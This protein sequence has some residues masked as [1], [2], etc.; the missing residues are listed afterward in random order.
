MNLEFKLK[1]IISFF[2]LLLFLILIRVGFLC[3]IDYEKMHKLS[4]LPRYK[5]VTLPPSRGLIADRGGHLLAG[6]QKRFDIAIIYQDIKAIPS[7]TYDPVTGTKSP[8][9]KLYISNLSQFLSS[10][11]DLT[12]Q[13][14]EDFIYAKSALFQDIP[15]TLVEDITLS[16]YH[17]LKLLQSQWPGLKILISQKRHYPHQKIGSHV[18]GFL[19]AIDQLTYQKAQEE[20]KQ[21]RTYI[22]QREKGLTPPLPKG[23]NTPFE[24]R[25]RFDELSQKSYNLVDFVGI[26]GVEKSCDHHLRGGCGKKAYET[27]RLGTFVSDLPGSF[28]KKRPASIQLCIDLALQEKA[29][30]LLAKRE[31][32][33]DLF[34]KG[35]AIVVL[36]IKTSQVL[37]LASYPRFNPQDFIDKNNAKIHQWTESDLYLR[38]LYEG[39]EQIE[40]ENF[41]IQKGFYATSKRLN[42]PL[43][44]QRLLSQNSSC[45]AALLNLP[46][47]KQGYLLIDSFEKLYEKYGFIEPSILLTQLQSNQDSDE[48]TLC[49]LKPLEPYLKSIKDPLLFLD[50]L[51]LLI[52][53]KKIK[54]SA[55]E[56][57]DQIDLSTFFTLYQDLSYILKTLESALQK[58]F[59]NLIFSSW[60]SEH[61]KTFL[62]EKRE[63]ET[64]QKTY[65]RPYTDYLQKEKNRQYQAFFKKYKIYM[66][67]FILNKLEHLKQELKE[68]EPTLTRLKTEPCL[69]LWFQQTQHLNLEQTAGLI[70]AIRPFEELTRP[71]YGH[72]PLLDPKK[73]LEKDLALAFYPKYK[74]GYLKS[75]AH[76]YLAP[77]GS[78]FKLVVAYQALKEKQE[79]KISHLPL[80]HDALSN[81][82]KN[83]KEQILGFD[84][85]KQPIRRWHKGGL[86]PR[87]SHAGIG[88]VDL[89]GA[90]EQSSNIYFSIL[91][92]ETLENPLELLKTARLMGLGSKTGIDLPFE[93]KGKL[94]NDLHTNKTGLYA[95]AIGQHELLVTPLQTAQMLA[96]LF[97]QG[98]IRKPQIVASIQKQVPVTDDLFSRCD[99]HPYTQSLS[100]LG[101]FFPLFTETL[102]Q[103]TERVKTSIESP[104][105]QS[106]TMN[107]AILDPLKKGMDR[108]VWGQKGT[109]R[110]QAIATLVPLDELRE[111]M[112]LKHLMIGKTGTAE[113]QV[114]DTF[115]Q[116]A[117]PRMLNHIWF[118]CISFEDDTQTNPEL[119]ICIYLKDG[120]LGVK[121]AAPLAAELIQFYQK[122]QKSTNSQ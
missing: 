65:A 102:K 25:T 97:D 113:Q 93:M 73:H 77:Q 110:P 50:L 45:H 32:C 11:C 106:Y 28:E 122:N 66:L 99:E 117:K 69:Q 7:Q 41:S 105:L 90:L 30:T 84:Q 17:Q 23:F 86:L 35:G 82:S 60:R 120:H 119:A 24:V 54:K 20:K 2:G 8:T 107:A 89:V 47:V 64:A 21:L 108:A 5:S 9:R 19:G 29:E 88:T 42:Y 57:L 104:L 56:P 14:I 75:H 81:E 91:A 16:A 12:P 1:K 112:H 62:K 53:P 115:D 76:R 95:F 101:C 103:K 71:L 63:Q 70:H 109:A 51:K 118:G 114:V 36:D 27:T 26:D 46:S 61:F 100:N 37:A 3:V 121:E 79:G 59:E 15:L 18:I 85:S 58:P 67:C 34:P 68:F 43:F 74:L 55:L 13:Q 98:Q 48:E 44:L 33:E 4:S 72:Y 49:L 40:K 38:K 94:P 31:T 80:I 83:K 52:D 78:I 92:S 96:S 39:L 111:Y 87:S 116:E 10:Y 22:Q 6:N